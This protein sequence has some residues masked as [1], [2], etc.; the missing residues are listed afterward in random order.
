[1]FV[2]QSRSSGQNIHC[3]RVMSKRVKPHAAELCQVQEAGPTS[4]S[5]ET[6]GANTQ[7]WKDGRRSDD[8]FQTQIVLVEPL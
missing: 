5:R 4:E 2:P 1:M 8:I 3:E 6:V 7:L